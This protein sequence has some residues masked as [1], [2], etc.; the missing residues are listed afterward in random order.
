MS[1]GAWD[2]GRGRFFVVN[3]Y[4]TEIM[5]VLQ[6]LTKRLQSAR[7]PESASQASPARI[8]WFGVATIDLFVRR[9]GRNAIHTFGPSVHPVRLWS[10]QARFLTM[11]VP[12]RAD[13][14]PNPIADNADC[15]I[16]SV[17][18]DPLKM[19]IRAGTN[20]ISYRFPAALSC[21]WISS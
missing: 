11:Q 4:I 15:R 20:D 7:R 12:R 6:V 13:V 9:L 21:P 14:T 10:S 8:P 1:T 2:S 19:P 5:S 3:N 16:P 18:L 17:C